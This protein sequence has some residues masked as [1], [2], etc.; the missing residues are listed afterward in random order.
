MESKLSDKIVKGITDATPILILAGFFLC[1]IFVG[2]MQHE[3]Y[4]AIFL[5]ITPGKALFM[6][7]FIPLSFGILRM[8]T[9]FGAA[10]LF[11]KERLGNAAFLFLIS[12]GI[13]YFEHVESGP[14][15]IYFAEIAQG[16]SQ[17]YQL[18]YLAA[19]WITIPI[20]IAIALIFSSNS[21]QSE[22]ES[23][24]EAPK[25]M[26]QPTNVKA[27]VPTPHQPPIPILNG[28]HGGEMANPLTTGN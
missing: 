15:S 1:L 19:I 21:K 13:A 22:P 24:T 8:S 17:A 5:E 16:D 14:M 18:L 6:G 10:Y 23:K 11:G 2:V 20:E 9:L 7:I 3:Y 28:A 26:L 25:P 4:Q 27:S 12:V